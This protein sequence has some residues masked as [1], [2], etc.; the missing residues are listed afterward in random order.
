VT[1][2]AAQARHEVWQQ[3]T[4][5]LIQRGKLSIMVQVPPALK[6]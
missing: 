4:R 2:D 3:L 6:A 1:L 5:A